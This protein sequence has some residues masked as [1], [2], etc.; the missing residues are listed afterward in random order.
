[1]SYNYEKNILELSETD[2]IK[3]VP[4]EWISLAP[5]CRMEQKERCIC[6]R[7]IMIVERFFNIK[8]KRV[9]NVGTTCVKELRLNECKSVNGLI[10]SF[11]DGEIG[12]YNQIIDLIKYS[13]D[14]LQKI[15]ATVKQMAASLWNTPDGLNEIKR[16]I[17]ILSENGID[18]PEMQALLSEFQKRIDYRAQLAETHRLW[19]EKMNREKAQRAEEQ[20]VIQEARH[21]EEVARLERQREANKIIE[22]EKRIAWLEE[23]RHR[24]NLRDPITLRRLK[25]EEELRDYNAKRTKIIQ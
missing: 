20:R 19:T 13:D 11:I 17:S 14:N 4:K 5:S 24:E 7:G 23:L 9:I 10:K 15:I 16:I 1:M 2:D 18:C 3:E 25:Q 22:E 12:E 6:N 21:R 8:T